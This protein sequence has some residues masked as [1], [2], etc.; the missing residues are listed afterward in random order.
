[1]TLNELKYRFTK[2]PAATALACLVSLALSS[3]SLCGTCFSAEWNI[4]FSGNAY[5]TAPT[6]SDQGFTRDQGVRWDDQDETISVFFHLD[7]PASVALSIRASTT[8]APSSVVASIGQQHFPFTIQDSTPKIIMIGETGDLPAG[9]ARVD[10]RGESKTSFRG[11]QATDLIVQSEK[12]DLEIRY[13]KNNQGNMFYWGRRG[14]S[15]HLRYHVPRDQKLTYAYSE[16]TVP[17]SLDPLGTYYMANGFAEG[18]FGIQVNSPTERR[19]L[20][21]VWSP[22]QTDNPRE[23]P[24]DQK[25]IALG[26]GEGVHLGEFGNEGSGGQS[27]LVYP[28]Q[29]GRTY[30]FLTEVIPNGNGQT[31]YTSWFGDVDQDEW[32]LVASFRRPKTD[33]HLRGFHSFLESFYP[34][35]GHK[36]R[37]A[38]YGNTWVRDTEGSWHACTKATFSVDATGGGGH[39]LDF[40]GGSDQNHFYLQNCG[41]F[42]ETQTAGTTFERTTEPSSPPKIDFDKLPR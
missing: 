5:R 26:R 3:L 12:S 13:V 1:M 24:E 8:S 9:Y 14:P 25:I 27:Y 40:T 22:F 39:R 20:F 41:F 42:N 2:L 10:L 28:W 38:N 23:I 34:A 29:S 7:Q 18:Y 21:S 17:E 31:T 36:E 19:V 30:R 33:T 37:R 32:R 4:P 11:I 16:I 15:V 35:H 6:S